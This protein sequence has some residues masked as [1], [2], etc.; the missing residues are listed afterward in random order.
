V[1][2]A[3]KGEESAGKF[4][5]QTASK[6]RA[7]VSAENRNLGIETRK[8]SPTKTAAGSSRGGGLSKK[9]REISNMGGDLMSGKDP[10][11]V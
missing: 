6:M 1:Y 7:A 2:K 10:N 8:T 9:E 3:L 11:E 4:K 5:N